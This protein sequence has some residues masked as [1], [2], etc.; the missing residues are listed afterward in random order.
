MTQARGARGTKRF[1]AS[2]HD[3][4]VSV[5]GGGYLERVG[6]ASAR[7]RDWCD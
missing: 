3:T 6:K 1:P 2:K 4:A 5:R 7:L